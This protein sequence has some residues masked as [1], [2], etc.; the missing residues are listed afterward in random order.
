MLSFSRQFLP[1]S[2]LSPSPWIPGHNGARRTGCWGRE[3]W[4]EDRFTN[5]ATC[6]I[7][8]PTLRFLCL[9]DRIQLWCTFENL[10]IVITK[11]HM[12]RKT[13][14]WWSP[15]CPRCVLHCR[16]RGRDKS[17]QKKKKARIEDTLLLPWPLAK[18]DPWFSHKP[19]SPWNTSPCQPR[20]FSCELL[21]YTQ[22][23]QKELRVTFCF[24]FLCV[25]EYNINLFFHN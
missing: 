16:A 1:G 25:Q 4:M 15:G 6:N 12:M 10:Q 18:R 3:F 2:V 19:P 17:L 22:H 8:L 14:E 24:C 5:E 21:P 11:T 7:R 13:T 20:S 23:P 9:A